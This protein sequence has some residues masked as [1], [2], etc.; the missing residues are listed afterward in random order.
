VVVTKRKPPNPWLGTRGW[1]IYEK[2]REARRSHDTIKRQ[3]YF[4]HGELR[5]FYTDKYPECRQYAK[6]VD[7]KKADEKVDETKE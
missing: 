2:K 7:E 6:R 3:M 5:S 1:E 4:E